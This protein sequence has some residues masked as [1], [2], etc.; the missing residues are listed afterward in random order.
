M[1]FNLTMTDGLTLVKLHLVLYCRGI[2]ESVKG[3]ALMKGEHRIAKLHVEFTCRKTFTYKIY[4]IHLWCHLH[5]S[6]FRSSKVWIW[7]QV[8]ANQSR[9]S[10][11]HV[12]FEVLTKVVGLC[13]FFFFFTSNHFSCALEILHF[14]AKF[15]KNIRTS[16]KHSFGILWVLASKI[17]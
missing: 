6:R 5:R 2:K 17:F 8:W 7:V 13:F 4:I 14:V 3:A 16:E 12:S 1:Q 11:W 15:S 9:P 10:L